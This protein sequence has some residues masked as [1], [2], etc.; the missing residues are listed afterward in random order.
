MASEK[1]FL[2]MRE[3]KN[4]SFVVLLLLGSGKVFN[5]CVCTTTSAIRDASRLLY[6][7]SS[8]LRLTLMS[9]LTGEEARLKPLRPGEQVESR[10]DP[11]FA[12]NSINYAH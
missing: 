8:T 2:V 7:T 11:R 10:L 1:G 6:L 4:V 9:H 12:S 3:Y 5:V